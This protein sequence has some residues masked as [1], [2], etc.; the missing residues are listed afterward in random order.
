[1][2][3]TTSVKTRKSFY[4]QSQPVFPPKGRDRAGAFSGATGTGCRVATRTRV[5]RSQDGTLSSVPCFPENPFSISLSVVFITN[6]RQICI[7]DFYLS[8]YIVSTKLRIGTWECK[9]VFE[10]MIQKLALRT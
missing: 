8:L 6:M 4:F 9:S 10:I 2:H 5:F 3:K 7:S 1:M